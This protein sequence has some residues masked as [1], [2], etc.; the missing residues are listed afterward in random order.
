M[1]EE[2]LKSID[3]KLTTIVKLL[4]VNAVKGKSEMEQMEFLDSMGMN[5]SEIGLVVGKSATN[6]RVQLSLSRKKKN[7]KKGDKK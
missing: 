2:V 7:R 3:D 4:A 6:V 1:N 5:S